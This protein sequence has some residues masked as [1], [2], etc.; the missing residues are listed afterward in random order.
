M[1]LPPHEYAR[2]AVDAQL[3]VQVEIDRVVLPPVTPGEAVVR[4]RVARVFRGEPSLVSSRISFEVSCLRE[5]DICPPS[6]T[7]WTYADDLEHARVIEAYLNRDGHGSY[8]VACSQ[9]LLLDAVTDTP[10]VVVTE[11]EARR[12]EE[13]VFGRAGATPGPVALWISDA[14]THGWPFVLIIGLM[15][16]GI[17]ALVWELVE[18]R[19]T[20]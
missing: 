1:A 13:E 7:L 14:L 20:P 10:V 16:A 8:H 12:L 15:L 3:H 9:S 19:R 18:W 6:G 11:E 2:A 4:G 17:G 5:G